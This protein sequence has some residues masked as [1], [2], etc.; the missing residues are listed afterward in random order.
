MLLSGEVRELHHDGR[1]DGKN[2]V[3]VLLFDELL[4]TNGYHAFLAITTIVS[5]D[6]NFIGTFA[7]LVFKN[8]KVFRTAS[9]D[10]E[11]TVAF[12]FQRL[13]D[14][15]HGSNAQSTTGTNHRTVVLDAGG[16]AKRTHDVGNI[17]ALVKSTQFL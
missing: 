5:H 13:Y 1:T 9:H 6:D 8:D 16:V 7:N 4:D 15:Q 3:Y 17:V 11:Y 14:R 10:G 2:L 12:G